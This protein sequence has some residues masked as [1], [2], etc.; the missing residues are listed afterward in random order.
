M[1]KAILKFPTAKEII[2]GCI[3]RE[4]G[5]IIWFIGA[6]NGRVLYPFV[7]WKLRSV[8]ELVPATIT[9]S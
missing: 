3:Q 2:A 9:S 7:S 1:A 6:R 4:G 8:F 5:E